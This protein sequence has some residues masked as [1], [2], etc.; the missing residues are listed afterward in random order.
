MVCGN[1]DGK[2]SCFVLVS[3]SDCNEDARKFIFMFI[4][5]PL[6]GWWKLISISFGA[7]LSLFVTGPRE[8]FSFSLIIEFILPKAAST[9]C[10]TTKRMKMPAMCVND[11]K[12]LC[13]DSASRTIMQCNTSEHS[14]VP[15]DADRKKSFLIFLYNFFPALH[16]LIH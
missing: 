8:A 10:D 15:S 16:I 1:A 12:A 6:Q 13:A 4:Y 11:N 5:T 7:S 2:C 9:T 14:V 3:L